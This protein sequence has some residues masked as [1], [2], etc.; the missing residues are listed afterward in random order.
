[1]HGD[2]EYCSD[3]Q[4]DESCSERENPAFEGGKG[5]RSCLTRW[6]R[7]SHVPGDARGAS[8]WKRLSSSAR[9]HLKWVLVQ[10]PRWDGPWTLLTW[11]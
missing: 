2:G 11:V 3:R 6:A 7:A 4:R 1:M 9:I 8:G 10:A 5:L